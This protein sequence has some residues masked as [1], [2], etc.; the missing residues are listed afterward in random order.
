MSDDTN[1]NFGFY[2]P[3]F[4]RLSSLCDT[5]YEIES[6]FA[7]REQDSLNNGSSN[8]SINNSR[9]EER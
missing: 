3:E 5:K 8:N 4:D 6:E 2:D 7:Q 9:I 1:K